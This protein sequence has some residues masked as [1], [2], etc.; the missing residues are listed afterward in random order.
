[1]LQNARRSGQKFLNPVLTSVGEWSTILKVL[2][3]YIRNKEEKVPRQP[4]GPFKTEVETY[5][6]PPASG[7]RVTW[8]GH[9]SVLVEIDGTNVL[10]DPVWDERASPVQWAGPKRFFA[11]PLLLEQLPRIDVALVSHDHYDHLGE[12]TIRKLS[13]MDSM[14]QARWVTSLGVGG[15]LQRF[16]VERER[17]SELDWTESV[18]VADGALEITAVPARHFSG[19][20]MGNRFE[21]LWSA[22]VLKSAAHKVYFGADSGWW[23]GFAE[24]GATYGPFDLTMLE[25]GAFHELWAE[26]HLGP[27]GAARAFA[28]MGGKGLMMPIHWG[29]FDLALHG[30]RQPTERLLELAAQQE[31]LLWM[32]EPG[33]PTE[34]VQ[35]TEVR[36]DWWR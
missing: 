9:S 28:A 12:T 24:I 10:I 26:I 6:L 1:M 18:T 21:T 32:P 2:P 19:R 33:R 7:L 14:K 3:L 22:F 35:G 34:V 31:I 4:L 8:M 29:L 23:D 25:I 15:I 16:G 20:K 11:A 36:S 5:R 30:W 17:I 27:D 13:R